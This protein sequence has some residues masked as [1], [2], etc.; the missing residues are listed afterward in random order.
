MPITAGVLIIYSV[1]P[2]P[3][4][5]TCLCLKQQWLQYFHQVALKAAYSLSVYAWCACV[6]ENNNCM[7]KV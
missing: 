5:L 2:I 3:L 7:K 1:F 4:P 6:E